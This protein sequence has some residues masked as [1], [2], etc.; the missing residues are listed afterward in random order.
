MHLCGNSRRAFGD[1]A[2]KALQRFNRP[3]RALISPA[4]YYESDWKEDNADPLSRHSFRALLA[5]I[6][7]AA[8]RRYVEVAVHSDLATEPRRTSA[9]YGLHN[10]LMNEPGYM[11]LYTIEGGIERLPQEL[12]RRS[13]ARVLLNHRVVR[14]ERTAGDAYR[15]VWRHGGDEQSGDFD[16]VVVALPNNWIPAIDWGGEVLAAAMDRHHA[17]YDYPGHYLRVS[18]L[19]GRPFWRDQV[20]GGA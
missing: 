1:E 13:G 20:A 14:V 17:Y 12:A 7:S 11:R 6:P 16:F 10:Y 9:A 4:E 15:V 2:G 5:R 3:A 8:A 19:F 18:V